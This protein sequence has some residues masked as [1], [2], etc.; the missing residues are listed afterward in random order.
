[1]PSITFEF[2]VGTIISVIC[3]LG[4]ALGFMYKTLSR[5]RSNDLSH[6]DAKIDDLK[7]IVMRVEDKLDKH[8]EYH[9]SIPR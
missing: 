3:A 4:A 9:L 2:N 6:I 1:M 8:I 7:E 5:I